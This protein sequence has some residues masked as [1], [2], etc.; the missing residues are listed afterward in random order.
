MSSNASWPAQCLSLPSSGTV[1]GSSA[2]RTPLPDALPDRSC[3]THRRCPL[4]EFRAGPTPVMGFQSFGSSPHCTRNSWCPRSST[5]VAGNSFRS[6]RAL[7]IR[8][9][10]FIAPLYLD[11]VIYAISRISRPRPSEPKVTRQRSPDLEQ[12]LPISRRPIPRQLGAVIGADGLKRR[13]PQDTRD[14]QC[15]KAAYSLSGN[16]AGNVCGPDPRKRICQ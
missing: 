6:R 1:S 8:M 3:E 14:R 9:T 5:T 16:E 4:P 11:S 12:R 15:Q 13:R 10:A 7:P 2:G